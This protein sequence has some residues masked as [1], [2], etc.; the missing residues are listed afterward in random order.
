M[1]NS[2]NKFF[3]KYLGFTLIELMIVVAII[4]ILAMIAVPNFLRY[5][6]KAK[7]SE[8]YL[9]LGSIYSAQKA[10]WAENGTYSSNLNTIGWKPEGEINYT[11]GFPGSEGVNFFTGKLKSPSSELT[12]LGKADKDSFVAVAVGDIDG[13]GKPDVVT[14][15][16][17]REIKIVQDDLA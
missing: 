4:A 14:I 1:K 15:N 2:S 11:Y 9:N 7:R 3:C 6:S 12:S 17:N 10:Y 5:V 13:D 16:Q 8:V